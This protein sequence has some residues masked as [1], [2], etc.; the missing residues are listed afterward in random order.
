[1]KAEARERDIF[2]RVAHKHNRTMIPFVHFVQLE[3][4]QMGMLP[5]RERLNRCDVFA[6]RCSEVMAL[7]MVTISLDRMGGIGRRV[8]LF[9]VVN[10]SNSHWQ[11]ARAL[12]LLAADPSCNHVSL[13]DLVSA[14]FTDI[15]EIVEDAEG[16]GRQGL[17]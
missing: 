10:D 17:L 1:M 7:I 6:M 9:G 3:L 11:C 15:V 12:S 8:T 14:Q 16:G 5:G 2:V 13:I 4:L